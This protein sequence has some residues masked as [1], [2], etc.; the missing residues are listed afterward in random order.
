VRDELQRLLLAG[1][2]E[3]G[4]WLSAPLCKELSSQLMGLSVDEQKTVGDLINDWGFEYSL[5][6]K[7]EKIVALAKRLGMDEWANLYED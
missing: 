6:A 5:S 4:I 3:G 2:D 1:I 7:K